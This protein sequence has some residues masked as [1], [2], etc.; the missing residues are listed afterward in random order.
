MSFWSGFCDRISEFVKSFSLFHLDNV[1]F[2]LVRKRTMRLSWH[3]PD[4]NMI[5][6]RV[7]NSRL[8]AEAL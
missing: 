3:N 6:C 5:I 8:K 7:N 2:F 4:P 1:W